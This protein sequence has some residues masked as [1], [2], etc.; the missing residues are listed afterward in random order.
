MIRKLCI[1]EGVRVQ[2]PITP[3]DLANSIFFLVKL[4]FMDKYHNIL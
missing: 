1:N 2:T 4:E 3:F